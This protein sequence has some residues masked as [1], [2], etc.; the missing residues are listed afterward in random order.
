[1]IKQKNYQV[2]N[3]CVMDT[4]DE[5][6]L[7]DENGVCERC[8]EFP[9]GI[10]PW[11][12]YGKGHEI[13]L[14]K[15][16]SDIKKK[17]KGKEYDCILGLSGGFDSSYMLHFAV[18]ELGLR[19]FVFHI[20]AGWNLPIAEDNIHNICNKLGVKLHI[21]KIDEE[22]MRHFQLAAFRTGLG[23]VLDVPQDHAFVSVL[24]KYARKLKI[25][26]ILNGGN[27]STEVVVNPRS[28]SKGCGA[29]TDMRFINDVLKHHCDIKLKKYPFTNVLMRKII[30]P[31]F[32]GIKNLKLLNY[33][34]Y[35]K[36]EA[37]AL[38][39]KEYDFI[40]YGQKHFEDIL[41]KFIEG[42]WLPTRFGFDIRRAQLSS[43]ITTGQMTREEALRILEKPPLAEEEVK[44]I[45]SIVAQKLKIT[46]EELMYLHDMPIPTYQ[47]KNS[48]W[49]YNI[50]GKIMYRLGL[51]RL[52]RR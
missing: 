14:A 21:E 49:M 30:M 34:P 46:E 37:E 48:R 22:E 25:K 10:L 7:F 2:C 51:D 38:L 35:I 33:V 43:L 18:R 50:G 9:K 6:I 36:K 28:W 24:D 45:F 15:I 31:Y 32:Y 23:G 11:W 41:T 4:T 12:N 42:Y 3:H 39:V 40:P 16:V 44:K 13:E 26:Y 47:Y 52:I 5:Y 20:D 27:I 19:P 29:G 1:M 8:N 17:G